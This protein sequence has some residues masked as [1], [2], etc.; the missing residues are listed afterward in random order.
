[1]IVESFFTFLGSQSGVVALC[2]QIFPFVIPQGIVPPAITFS[3]D[4]D[5]RQPLLDG[6]GSL[7]TALIEVNAW[8]LDHQNAHQI[9]EAIEAA[10]ANHRGAFG[11]KTAEQIRLERK[12]ELLESDTGL[13]RVSQQFFI[14]YY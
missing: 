2:P 6:V 11:A 12:F 5:D 4:S 1:M 10:L 9:A 14:A 8:S 3:L 7:R 13:Y